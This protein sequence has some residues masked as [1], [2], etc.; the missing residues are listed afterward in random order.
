LPYSPH[1]QFGAD[2]LKLFFCAT[3]KSQAATLMLTFPSMDGY[4]RRP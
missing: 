3:P 4:E 1:Q 2:R